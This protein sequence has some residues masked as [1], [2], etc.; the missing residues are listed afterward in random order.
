MKKGNSTDERL[1]PHLS[2]GRDVN[3]LVRSKASRVQPLSKTLTRNPGSIIKKLEL[4]KEVE[5]LQNIQVQRS[6]RT[7]MEGLN[8]TCIG[9]LE[10]ARRHLDEK[11]KAKRHENVVRIRKELNTSLEKDTVNS[12]NKSLHRY[13]TDSMLQYKQTKAVSNSRNLSSDETTS[14]FTGHTKIKNV[15][16]DCNIPSTF[17]SDPKKSSKKKKQSIF[18]PSSP[19]SKDANVG[20]RDSR[21]F[22]LPQIVENFTNTSK[23]KQLSTHA[24]SQYQYCLPVLDSSSKFSII[25]MARTLRQNR[26]KAQEEATRKP[27]PKRHHSLEEK[28]IDLFGNNFELLCP[29]YL[30]EEKVTADD[31]MRFLD[32]QSFEDI[33][34]DDFLHIKNRIVNVSPAPAILPNKRNATKKL[35]KIDKIRGFR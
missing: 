10:S 13:S 17:I 18:S 9:E 31:P 21:N 12:F 7:L 34:C 22:S 35:M 3:F 11:L 26:H 5:L 4:L 28:T 30:T 25:K 23:Q 32:S 29:Q 2:S 24:G 19:T 14:A 16:D 8:E 15:F 33:D 6:L 27:D 20:S 1:L